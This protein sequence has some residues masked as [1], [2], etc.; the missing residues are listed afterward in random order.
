M[1]NG[2]QNLGSQLGQLIFGKP[3]DGEAYYKGQALGAQVQAN[4]ATAEDRMAAARKAR[5]EAIFQDQIN[6]NHAQIT[7]EN[8][9]RAHYS[10]DQAPLLTAILGSNKSP[11]IDQLGVMAIPQAGQAFADAADATRLGD[12]TT[13]NRQLALASG[14]PLETTAISDGMAYNKYA[15][16]DQPMNITALGDAAIDLRHAQAG[17]S[18]A[19]AANSYA[20]AAKTRGE[21][22]SN[23]SVVGGGKAA[24]WSIQQ[25]ADGQLYRVNKLDGRAM[26][27]VTQGVQADGQ[28]VVG[29]NRF[30]ADAQEQKVGKQR[31]ALQAGDAELDR[32]ASAAQ[33]V[34]DSGGLGGIT[35][36]S[37]VFPNMPGGAAANTQAKLD[38]LKSQVGFSVLQNMRNN[39]P[40]GGALGQVSDRENEMLQNNLAALGRA[41]SEDEYRAQLQK[42]IDFANGSKTRRRDAFDVTYG[43]GGGVR[44]PPAGGGL[45][46]PGHV[47]GGFRFKG[48][49]P[50]NPSNWEQL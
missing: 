6:A 40:T 18:R 1:P 30:K 4:M 5:A 9:V 37:G 39:S 34:L 22:G 50:S 12:M 36:L 11:S 35:G 20:S 8:M 19:S 29:A 26:P 27:V 46:Q 16:T 33:E 24:D 2:A 13:A 15:A 38:A 43:A 44:P 10:A 7:P 21:M 3:D 28:P 32:L 49:D 25:G 45:P 47:E 14:K 42:I 31:A 23:G 41:Q 48:G 17:A